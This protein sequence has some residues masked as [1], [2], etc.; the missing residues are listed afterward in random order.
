MP[1]YFFNV[2]DGLDISDHDGTVLPGIKEARAA[3]ITAAGE[4]I[5]DL[6]PQFWESHHEWQM[7]VTDESGATVCKLNFSAES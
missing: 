5:Q 1:R 2:R 7:H 4:A 3:A 6:G